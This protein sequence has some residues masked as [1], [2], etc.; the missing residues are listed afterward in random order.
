MDAKVERWSC[1]TCLYLHDFLAPR[2]SVCNRPRPVARSTRRRSLRVEHRSKMRAKEIQKKKRRAAKPADMDDPGDNHRNAPCAS[3]TAAG[4]EQD[5][6]IRRLL[7]QAKASLASLQEVTNTVNP[8]S[9]KRKSCADSTEKTWTK[10]TTRR[11]RTRAGQDC[12]V[13]GL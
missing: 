3:S 6:E 13:V 11:R 1:D 2:C 7:A 4:D 5:L 10:S 9:K 8:K 12:Q